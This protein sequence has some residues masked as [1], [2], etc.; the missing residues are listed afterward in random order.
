MAH[1]NA[2][3]FSSPFIPSSWFSR[4]NERLEESIAAAFKYVIFESLRLDMQRRGKIF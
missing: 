4:I 2:N 1:M 3:R